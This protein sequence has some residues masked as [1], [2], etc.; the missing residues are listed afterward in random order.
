MSEVLF[1]SQTP[2]AGDNSD[3]GATGISVGTAVTFGVNGSVPGIQFYATTTVPGSGQNYTAELWLPNPAD[4]NNTATI[5]ATKTIDSSLVVAGT[6]NIILFAVPVAV[7]AGTVYKTVLNNSP[8]VG[9][10]VSTSGF[11]GSQLVNG[12]ITGLAD[13]ATVAGYT[14]TINNGS[15]AIG[16]GE[17]VYPTNTFGHNGYFVGP[18][19]DAT[20]AAGGGGIQ[21]LPAQLITQL[22]AGQGQYL[23]SASTTW[24]QNPTDSAG[25]TDTS[26]LTRQVVVIDLAGLTDS[27]VAARAATTTDTVGLT[28]TTAVADTL[29]TTDSAGLTDAVATT[30]T[31]V[32]TDSAGITDTTS[33][34]VASSATD[35]AGLTDTSVTAYGPTMTDQVGLTD[36]ATVQGG[37]TT[38]PIAYS[39]DGG[40]TATDTDGYTTSGTTDGT[41]IITGATS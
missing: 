40:T 31:T 11:W 2:V 26:A 32:V 5:L 36:Q 28:D 17:G 16:A 10:Y 21:Q 41:A 38:Q 23:R 20:P 39:F 3:G 9:R 4:P 18:L 19:F 34:T 35:T 12:N 6:W 30:H 29:V 1:T 24:T 7:T 15:F 22:L 13:G 33:A 27:S 14:G 8:G 37:T 25:L